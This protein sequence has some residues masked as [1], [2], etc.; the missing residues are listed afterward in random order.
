MC[1]PAL[2]HPFVRSTRLYEAVNFLVRLLSLSE[3]KRLYHVTVCTI[4][5]EKAFTNW[6]FWINIDMPVWAAFICA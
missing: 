3:T 6:S 1:R 4:A 5:L 2:K